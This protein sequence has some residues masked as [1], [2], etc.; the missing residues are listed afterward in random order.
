MIRTLLL[1]VILFNTFSPDRGF[2]IP[3]VLPVEFSEKSTVEV[4]A[5]KLT[6]VKTQ[7]PFD[8]YSLGFCRPIDHLHYKK[9]NLGE[10]F[11]GDRIVNTPF[12]VRMKQNEACHLVCASEEKMNSLSVEETNL[13][14]QRIKEEYRVH[15][16]VDNL[17]CATRTTLGNDG[18][19]TFVR[20]YPLGFMIGDETYV[21]NHLV[22]FLYYNKVGPNAYRIVGFEVEALSVDH[23]TYSVAGNSCSS[24]N[25]KLPQR[26][27]KSSANSL[28]WSYSV[29]WRESDI[30]WTN[31]WDKYLAM[32]N[33]QIHWLSIVNST[34]TVLFL[35]GALGAIIIR[36]VRKDIA[37]YN[38]LHDSDDALEESGWKLIHGDIFRPPP[39]S[40][41]LVAL[42]GSGIQVFGMAL[43]TIVLAAIGMLSP[44]SRGALMSTA[45]FLYC[46]MGLFSGYFAG[47]LYKT[48]RLTNWKKAAIKTACLFPGFLFLTGF[49]LNMLTASQ[50]ASNAL[51]FSSMLS[52]LSMFVCIDIPLVMVAFRFGFR[53]QPYVNPVRTNQIPRQVPEQP[54]YLN[55]MFSMLFAGI[56]PFLAVFL[57][58]FFIFSAMWQNQFYY[59]FGFL[60]IV[61]IIL[62]VSTA[63]ISVVIVYFLLAAE[64][65]HWWWRAFFI[66][67]SQAI[68]VFLYSVYYYM[69]KLQMVGFT[70]KI[71]Y[72]SYTFL[73]SITFWL[74]AGTVGFY[75]AYAFVRKIYSAVK[76]D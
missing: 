75:A 7:L 33:T 71:L 29:Q 4:K 47:R 43:S 17:P 22:F 27:D 76:I 56:V 28:Y 66:G 53:K 61:F 14:I 2:Y 73:I 12:V 23:S 35:A 55:L 1:V 51:S 8:Y 13:M 34:V 49:V 37:Q 65:Y 68:Y 60:F 41:L 70:A 59:L 36:I 46:F 30:Q 11:R 18:E 3:G 50:H 67:G 20:G 38:R 63:L 69:T 21:N 44:S 32:H 15:L 5:V 40:T 24:L 62:V 39:R 10:I 9:E 57:E 45:L 74:L 16:L 42:V 31:R 72:F 52:L 6:S 19:Y 64:N 58:L 26:L 25:V 48:F 54:I